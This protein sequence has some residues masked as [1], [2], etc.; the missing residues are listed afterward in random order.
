M[1]AARRCL[2]RFLN[3]ALPAS[4]L[5]TVQAKPLTGTTFCCNRLWHFCVSAY[6]K[7]MSAI[8]TYDVSALADGLY[9]DGIVALKG[10]FS[11]EWADRLRQDIEALLAEALQRPDGAVGRGPNR[12]YVEIHPERLRGFVDIVTHPWVTAVNEAILGPDY[13]IVEAGFDVPLAGAQNQPWH[14]DFPS[15]PETYQGHRL[16]SLAFNLTA[17][18][19][20]PEMAPFEIAPGTQWESGLAFDHGMFPDKSEYP[21]YEALAQRKLPQRGD[22]SARSALVLH[23]GTVNHTQTARP[24]LVIG[25]LAP[26]ADESRNDLVISRAYHETLPE[27]LKRHLGARI[28][29]EL[30]PLKQK[31]SIEG[32]VMGD[33]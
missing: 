24:V 28:V 9:S 27:E 19:T 6:G 18:D 20:T 33:A 7:R 32:L 1:M 12:Y 30:I 21:R 4:N 23:R 31:H 22:I 13:R 14:R 2:S 3:S 25:F 11:P 15:P 8:T 26:G 29:D 17:V 16:T 5:M 10:A